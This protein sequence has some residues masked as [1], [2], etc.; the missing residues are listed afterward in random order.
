MDKA[1]RWAI[2]SAQIL[3]QPSLTAFILPAKP[4]T[5]YRRWLDHPLL[6]TLLDLPHNSLV[7]A[8]E[9]Q[10]TAAPQKRSGIGRTVFF[11]ANK[12]ALAL[13]DVVKLHESLTACSLPVSWQW[14][15]TIM[16][17][18]PDNLSKACSPSPSQEFH[19][20]KAFSKVAQLT[21]ILPRPQHSNT[22]KK[23]C[24]TSMTRLPP[25]WPCA[26]S[27]IYTDGSAVKEDSVGKGDGHSLNHIGSGVF[28]RALKLSL[29]VDPC[30]QGAT[31]TIT[32]AE[33][34]A[35]TSSL[36]NV[37]HD[38]CIIATDSLASMY[39][40]LHNPAKIALSPPST[41]LESIAARLCSRATL[42]LKATIIK[43]K[44]HTGIA[45]NER[46]DTLANEARDPAL[47]DTSM[48]QGNCAHGAHYWPMYMKSLP[49][50]S[51]APDKFA[52][53]LSGSLKHHV[54]SSCAR[55]FANP[56]QYEDYWQTVMPHLHKCSFSFWTSLRLSEAIR[57]QVILAIFGQTWNM[58]QAWKQGRPYRPG[59]QVPRCPGCPL[60]K[61]ADSIGHMLGECSHRIIKSIIIERHNHA[62]RLILGALHRG[63]QGNC[64]TIADIGSQKK[65]ASLQQ[66]NT[67]TPDFM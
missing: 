58:N 12:S 16:S 32:R 50:A 21:L 26:D 6:H 66:H 60:C 65:M 33:L 17:C 7:Q 62:A 45:G 53:D 63:S 22:G 46:A 41:L 18:S 44:A 10:N 38:D 61:H 19:P 43:V 30:G 14:S 54:S 51:L 64:Y 47:C 28:C 4:S 35:I 36:D 39:M 52:A 57:R 34:V 49:D 9:A 67:R 23:Q 48:S 24:Y 2:A 29:H 55:G 27:I 11:V 59:M 40:M 42:G 25:A 31:N 5:A 1:V 56:S 13:I 3:Q 15:T 37:Q 8:S 20:P